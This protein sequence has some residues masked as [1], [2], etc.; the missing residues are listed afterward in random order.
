MKSV[1]EKWRA[2]N[3]R[4]SAVIFEKIKEKRKSKK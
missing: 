3:A 1:N 2:D 4:L